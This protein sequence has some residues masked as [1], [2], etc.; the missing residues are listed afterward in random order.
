MQIFGMPGG[1]TKAFYGRQGAP[2]VGIMC[3]ALG[4]RDLTL[5]LNKEAKVDLINNA[6]LP[7]FPPQFPIGPYCSTSSGFSPIT[8]PPA[9]VQ[10]K[11]NALKV[12]GARNLAL[13]VWA[14]KVQSRFPL[15]PCSPLVAFPT[16]SWPSSP[17][18]TVPQLKTA[19]YPVGDPRWRPEQDGSR[20][21]RLPSWHCRPR[22]PCTRGSARTSDLG[23]LLLET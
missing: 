15:R 5:G 8:H 1:D 21:V 9:Q 6:P 13:G 20:C 14:A 4:S 18:L 19:I 3:T 22:S 10:T 12:C 7:T 17:T 16:S 23:M 11:K 2:V